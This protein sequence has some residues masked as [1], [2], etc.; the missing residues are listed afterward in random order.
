MSTITPY[1]DPGSSFTAQLKLEAVG[2][3]NLITHSVEKMFIF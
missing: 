2:T 3:P 1:P